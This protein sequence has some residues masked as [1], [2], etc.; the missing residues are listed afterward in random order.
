VGA[1]VSTLEAR[2]ARDAVVIVHGDHGARIGAP[3]RP[4]GQPFTRQDYDD[5]FAT[6][7]A[8]RGPGVTPGID[9]TVVSIG[10][11]LAELARKDFVMASVSPDAAP[12]VYRTVDED[13]PLRVRTPIPPP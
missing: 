1:L 11:L 9:S 4:A 2:G 13:T 12:A 7:F 5:F 6:L 8:V 10:H 3:I